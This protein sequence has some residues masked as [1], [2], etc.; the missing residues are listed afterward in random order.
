MQTHGNIFADIPSKLDEELMQA[1]WQTDHLK[2]ERIIS[3]G[4][5]TPQ[6]EWYDQETDEWVM[7]LQG[8]AR[9]RIE[10]EE[11]SIDLKPGDYVFLPA[12]KRHRVEWTA[13]DQKTVWLA[14]H[15][16]CI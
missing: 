12:L 7:L 1:L 5:V 8:A 9:L 13:P 15:A 16:K 11:E 14:L 3:R 2:L 6:G 10:G 4:H